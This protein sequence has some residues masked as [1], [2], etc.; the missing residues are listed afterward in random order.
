[1]VLNFAQNRGGIPVIVAMGDDMQLPHVSAAG[2]YDWDVLNGKL[3]DR[4]D[5]C[6]S[7]LGASG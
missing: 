7:E 5:A 2:V 1:M 3:N 6:C 4:E